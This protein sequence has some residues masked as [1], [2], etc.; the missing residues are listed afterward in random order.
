VDEVK[1]FDS[2][3][4]FDSEKKLERGRQIIDAEPSAIISTTKLH[5]GEP[6]DPEEGES[7]F[8]S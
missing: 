3:A 6:D 2:D 1:S 7:L 5:P 4:G 8:H